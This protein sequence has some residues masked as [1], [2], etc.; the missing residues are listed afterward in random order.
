MLSL[1]RVA[2]LVEEGSDALFCAA[3]PVEVRAHRHV[4]ALGHIPAGQGE[5]P[6]RHDDPVCDPL[7]EDLEVLACHL[8]AVADD[9]GYHEP[10]KVAVVSQFLGNI[11]RGAGCGQ[12]AVAV[13]PA[14]P[15]VDVEF[16]FG[17]REVVVDD[18]H[19]TR[20]VFHARPEIAEQ[21]RCIPAKIGQANLLPDPEP[22]TDTC[23]EHRVAEDRGRGYAVSIVVCVHLD[24]LLSLYLFCHGPRCGLKR[25]GFS[26][27]LC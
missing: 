18:H 5:P 27:R 16:A 12:F 14:K 10:C 15:R 21:V 11:V 26:G 1:C 6:V 8:L 24:E 25:H 2:G 13:N 17:Q 7:V 19:V 22:E 9:A 4:P 23:T 3:D 20:E